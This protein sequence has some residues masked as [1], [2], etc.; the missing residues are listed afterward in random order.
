MK[1][2]LFL[3][4]CFLAVGQSEADDAI[5]VAKTRTYEAI[6]L[7][8]FRDGMSHWRKRYGR[9]RNDVMYDPPQ[10]VHIAEN[11]LVYQN[12]DGGWPNNVDW[13]A[14][15]D[16]DTVRAIKGERR[17]VSTF[18]NHNTFTQIDY[19][20]NVYIAT[21]LDRYQI[22]VEKGLHYVFRE[23]R[24]TGGWRG[25]D[26]DA[27]TY[28]DG[29]MIGVM[30]LL[31]DVV[32]G[33]SQFAWVSDDLRNRAKAS[34]D[35]AMDATLRCQIVVDGKKTGWCQ[36]HDHET[37]EP[38]K[39][40]TYELPSI[41]AGQTASIV[42]FLMAIEDP[43]PEV[44]D[45]IE[46]AVRWFD[47]AK[48]EG[49]RLERVE[50]DPMRFKDHTATTDLVMVEDPNAPPLWARFHEIGTNRPFMANRDGKK[51]YSLSEVALERR[52]G[53]A[54][55]G[56]WPARILEKEYPE[57]KARLNSK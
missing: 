20:A 34:L 10:I 15:I 51:V 38:V 28:N 30:T 53:Y 43:S 4:C 41:T 50:I 56:G 36:Q 2:F 31:R 5:E 54:W 9:D 55:Y 17:M 25:W 52:T 23:Q 22:A 26:V 49:I 44:V 45:A 33:K 21:G 32:D 35:H 40:R 6:D 12:A 27:I 11:V 48:I 14:H 3:I 19:L 29:V 1:W 16:P 24:P 7:H 37:F 46:S 8:P 18:D 57:W 47:E 13:Q 39:A 42:R